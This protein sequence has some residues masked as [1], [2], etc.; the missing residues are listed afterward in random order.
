MAVAF[1]AGYRMAPRPAPAPRPLPRQTEEA[2]FAAG[3]L[4]QDRGQRKGE[5]AADFAPLRR[6]IEDYLAAQPATY[7]VY[8]QDLKSGQSFGIGAEKPMTAASTVKVLT[9]LYLYTLAA[10]EKV[11]LGEKLSYQPGDYQD[12]SGILAFVVRP[13]DQFSLQTLANLAITVSDNIAHK[14]LLRRLGRDKVAG[15]TRKLGLRIAF[16]NDQNRTTAADLGVAL[17]AVLDLQQ[18][19]P[20]WGSLLLSEMEHT[21]WNTGLNSQL[22]AEVR[23]AHKY[24]AAEGIANDCGI[25]LGARPYILVVLSSGLDSVTT[26]FQRIAH[27]SRLVYDYEQSLSPPGE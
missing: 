24:G 9:V 8:F 7:T 10:E 19:H 27:I 25:V 18:K 16:P 20:E 11:D 6:E 5:E 4:L 1:A 14:M 17:R 21:T 12:G 23:V 3:S 13:G 22:P 15:F 2:W 26:G